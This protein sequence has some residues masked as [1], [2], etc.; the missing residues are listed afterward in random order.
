[1]ELKVL[2]FSQEASLNDPTDMKCFLVLGGPN[3]EI[4]VQIEPTELQKVITSA[5]SNVEMSKASEQSEQMQDELT[6]PVMEEATV[7]GE[8][9]DPNTL[10]IDEDG[11]ESL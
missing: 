2:R 6:E 11:I 10:A 3:G 8:D 4:R 5:Y 7:Y 1:M 9:P